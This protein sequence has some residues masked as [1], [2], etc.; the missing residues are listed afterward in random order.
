MRLRGGGHQRHSVYS[1][2]LAAMLQVYSTAAV[3]RR[4]LT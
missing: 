2:V 3:L 1:L 4:K